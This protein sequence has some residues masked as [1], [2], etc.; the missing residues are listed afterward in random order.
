V[1]G[2]GSDN[3]VTLAIFQAARLDSQPLSPLF[4]GQMKAASRI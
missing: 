2:E 3:R 1:A 4:G